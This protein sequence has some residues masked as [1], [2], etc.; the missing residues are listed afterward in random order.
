[1]QDSNIIKFI[2]RDFINIKNISVVLHMYYVSPLNIIFSNI[3]QASRLS[4][5]A[6]NK[7]RRYVVS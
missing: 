6:I 5:R 7:K 3:I 4:V 2:L 1:M